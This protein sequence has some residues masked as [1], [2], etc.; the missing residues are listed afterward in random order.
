M[1][2]TRG[3][4]IGIDGVTLHACAV[5]DGSGTITMQLRSLLAA[6][7]LARPWNATFGVVLKVHGLEASK[8]WRLQVS[9]RDVGHYSSAVLHAGVMVTSD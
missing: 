9:G 1:D 6:D 4:C 3:L 5:L 2:A 8:T 7:S